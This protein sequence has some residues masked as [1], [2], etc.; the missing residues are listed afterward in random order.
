MAAGFLTENAYAPGEPDRVVL[1]VSLL[2][3]R[4][5]RV[6]FHET[7]AMD[8]WGDAR[9]SAMG[10]LVSVPV[11]LAVESVLAREIPAGVHPAPHDPRLIARWMGEVTGL[12]QYLQRIDHL[13]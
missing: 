9:G 11:S 4:A 8:A 13:A 5:G 2:A 1:F 10:R 12:V 3:Q 6:V 7:W